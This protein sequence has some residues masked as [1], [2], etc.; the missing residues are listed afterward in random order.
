M[1]RMASLLR[2]R[3]RGNVSAPSPP[4]FYYRRGTLDGAGLSLHRSSQ[5]PPVRDAGRVGGGD[6]HDRARARREATTLEAN[7]RP[8]EPEDE[9]ECA[10]PEPFS[11]EPLAIFLPAKRKDF[12]FTWAGRDREAGRDTDVS[13]IGCGS[14]KHRPSSG[15]DTASTSICRDTLAEGSGPMRKTETCCAWTSA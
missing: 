1:T 3:K 12:V 4:T 10:D 5:K 15:K 13:S 6:G 14:T 11:E 2:W 9:P 8:A 7:G